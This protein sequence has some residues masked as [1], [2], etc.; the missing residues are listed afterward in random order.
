MTWFAIALTAGLLLL[1]L[2]G[3]ATAAAWTGLALIG[4]ASFLHV[5]YLAQRRAAKRMPAVFKERRPILVPPHRRQ[6]DRWVAGQW[7]GIGMIGAGGALTLRAAEV[8]PFDVLVIGWIV[9]WS[10]VYVSSL[11]DWYLIMPKVAGISCPGPCERSG[12]QRW[13]GV[14]G[15]W[16]FHRGAARLGVPLALI[17]CPTII[18]AL[19]T[20]PTGQAVAFAIAA[21]LA[22]YLLDFEV[23]GKAALNYGLNGRRHVGDVLWLVRES[24]AEVTRTP[25]FLVDVSAEGG[26]FKYVDERGCFDGEPFERKHDDDESVTL[27]RLTKRPLVNDALAPCAGGCTG[28]NWYC[29]NNPLAHSQTTNAGDD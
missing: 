14:T 18:G 19:T 27:D 21:A 2:G 1:A 11:I 24:A 20:S 22:V 29:W 17:G 25:A 3:G 10:S 16:C 12:Q 4:T 7:T 5:T 9:L 13:A 8:A 23:Q 28:I 15:L 6:L 26:K